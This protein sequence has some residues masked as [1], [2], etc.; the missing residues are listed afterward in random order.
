MQDNFFIEI[1]SKGEMV[2]NRT[3]NPEMNDFIYKILS[4]CS[5][6]N[7]RD[8]KEFLDKGEDVELLF[9]E[10]ILCG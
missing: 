7:M 5:N 6:E 4:T 8:I 3:D 2:Y 1:S 9:G 10:R